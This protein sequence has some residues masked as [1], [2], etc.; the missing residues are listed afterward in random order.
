[1]LN[2]FFPVDAQAVRPYVYEDERTVSMHFDM[3]A[4]QSRMRRADPFALDLDYTRLMMGCLLMNRAPRSV[5]MIGLGGG[6][7]AKY[8][9]RHLAAS[10]ITVVEINPHV[11]AMRDEFFVPPD[12]AR[13]R[14]VHADGAAWIASTRARYEVV[15]VDGFNYDGQPEEL[16]TPA[17]YADCR[18][19]LAP[20]G[21]LAVNL[22]DEEP[23]CDILTG[24][25]AREFES[26]T[27]HLNNDSG[28]NRIVFASDEGVLA[29]AA[30][31]FDERWAAL[32]PVHRQTLNRC[33]VQLR[34]RLKC[35]AG[36]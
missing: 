10:D 28:G 27:L 1:L 32:D 11:I 6:S 22:H 15:M 30:A 36:G 7:L 19:S 26:A 8:C 14:V 18:A 33:A 9:H 34:H 4:T 25:I 2:D 16:C 20:G 12:S 21:V 24:R 5:L 31:L 35:Y 13:F 3:S 23:Q 17:F 29:R